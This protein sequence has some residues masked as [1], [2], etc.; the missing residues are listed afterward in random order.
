MT[1]MPFVLIFQLVFSGD[2]LSLPAWTNAITP[3]TISNPAL[4]VLAAQ[5]EY[6]ARP[7]TT[8]WNTVND[9][10]DKEVSKPHRQG[11]KV[12]EFQRK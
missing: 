4:K 3:L 5:C 9:M 8:I 6:N 2:M 1:V 11:Q 10:R 12:I 7:V